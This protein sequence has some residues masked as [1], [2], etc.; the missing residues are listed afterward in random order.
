MD[1]EG[2]WA[3]E[4]EVAAAASLLNCCIHLYSSIGNPFWGPRWHSHLPHPE[5]PSELPLF[6]RSGLYIL[7]LNQNHFLAVIDI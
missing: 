7:H 6:D 4:V 2:S 1:C 3:G 5:L